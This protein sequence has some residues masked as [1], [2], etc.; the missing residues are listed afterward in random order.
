MSGGHDQYENIADDYE[1]MQ[2]PLNEYAVAFTTFRLLG[3]VS[4]MAFLDLACGTGLYTRALRRRGAAPVLGVD[5]SE[6][7]VRV[8]RAHE[9]DN[10]LGI[11]YTI[12]DV[13]ALGDLGQFDRA[14][15]IYLLNYVPSREALAGVAGGIARNLKPGAR[16]LAFVLN[17]DFSRTPDYYRKYGVEVHFGDELPDGQLMHFALIIGDTVSPRLAIHYWSRAGLTSAF[18]EAGFTN[19]RWI[20]PELSPQGAAAYGDEFWQDYLRFP[21]GIFLECTKA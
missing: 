11:E 5:I 18:E 8:A 19:V 12:A 20:E 15:A 21:H 14:T 3:D 17:P 4:G 2:V 9:A 16:L 13:A 7:M 1:R 10:P 6:E